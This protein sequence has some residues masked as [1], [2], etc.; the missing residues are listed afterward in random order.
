MKVSKRP[1]PA[2]ASWRQF[3]LA[4]SS[5][6]KNAGPVITAWKISLTKIEL[7]LDAATRFIIQLT[8]AKKVVNPLPLGG[9]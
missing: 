2:Y 1:F 7:P 9:N 3:A 5:G 6:A 4:A 8:A